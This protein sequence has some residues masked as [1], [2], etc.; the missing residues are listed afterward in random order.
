MIFP[1]SKC[2]MRIKTYYVILSMISGRKKWSM[3]RELSGVLEM[4][5]VMWLA[6]GVCVCVCVSKLIELYI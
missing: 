1:V 4:T 5:G 3:I 2:L 6:W